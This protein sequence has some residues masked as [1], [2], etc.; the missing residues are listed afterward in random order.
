MTRELT[1]SH[2]VQYSP[3]R[4]IP[5]DS[6]R[7]THPIP[8]AL[9]AYTQTSSPSTFTTPRFNPA[10]LIY[11][12]HTPSRLDTAWQATKQVN[13]QSITQLANP[14]DRGRQNQPQ[15]CQPSLPTCTT[16]KAIPI[17]P[18][19]P[20]SHPGRQ[21]FSDLSFLAPSC[22]V[23]WCSVTACTSCTHRHHHRPVDFSSTQG[24]E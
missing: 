20:A 8:V 24:L 2:G 22:P 13:G 21:T 14:T 16:G 6:S 11:P 15:P 5:C 18:T 23:L 9:P 1:S 4:T 3:K 12:V 10:R 17:P 7:L 19:T